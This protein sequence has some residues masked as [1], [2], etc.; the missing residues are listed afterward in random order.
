L[1]NR[2][3]SKIKSALDRTRKKRKR[4]IGKSISKFVLKHTGEVWENF[5]L[6]PLEEKRCIVVDWI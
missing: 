6:P 2:F 1:W 4:K 3:H 5:F